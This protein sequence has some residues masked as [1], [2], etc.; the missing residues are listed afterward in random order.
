MF[1]KLLALI[2]LA[3]SP[4]IVKAI[5]LAKIEEEKKKSYDQLVKSPFKYEIIKDFV[6]AASQG[7]TVRFTIDGIPI[8]I[9]R[10]LPDQK[11]R[12]TSE[13]F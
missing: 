2:K 13:T 7:V 12:F 3:N 11:N 6:E 8:E 4:S 10:D 1:N 5:E 9:K